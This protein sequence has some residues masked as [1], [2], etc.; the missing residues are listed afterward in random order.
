VLLDRVWFIETG[1]L[2]DDARNRYILDP[3][4]GPA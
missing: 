3:T 1:G 2:P 4:N